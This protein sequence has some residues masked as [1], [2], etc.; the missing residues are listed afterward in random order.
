M[1]KGS[2]AE[3][4]CTIPG[5]CMELQGFLDEGLFDKSTTIG[6][7][8]TGQVSYVPKAGSVELKAGMPVKRVAG[9]DRTFELAEDNNFDAV[10]RGDLEGIPP[11]AEGDPL[12]EAL[13][14][15]PVI[16][17]NYHVP[18]CDDNEEVEAGDAI[19]WTGSKWDKAG[20]GAE[21]NG[22]VL[23]AV[24]GAS[25][26]SGKYIDCF[27]PAIAKFVEGADISLL[28]TKVATLEE[29][30]G[31][32]ETEASIVGAI[33]TISQAIG[34]EDTPASILGRIKALESQE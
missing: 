2:R 31:D 19:V 12:R 6:N 20:L 21:I 13:L 29:V 33:K 25:A 8:G 10:I 14:E 15:F 1:V 30:I 28:T 32:E 27:C 4:F 26:N 5:K 11:I 22:V 3:M 24:E 23:I 17:V 18:L 16:G 34:D 9:K 7:Y